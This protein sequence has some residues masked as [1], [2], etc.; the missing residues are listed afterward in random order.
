MRLY[1]TSRLT[2]KVEGEI[3]FTNGLVLRVR[4]FV[5]FRIARIVDYSYTVLRGEERIR[6]Y[7]SQPHP[8]DAS[9]KPTFPHHYHQEPNIK[10]HRLPARAISFTAPNQPTLIADC[11]ALGQS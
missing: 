1:S 8:E 9:L 6:Y 2:V 3:Q 4:E 10:H 11:V 5:D 7:D